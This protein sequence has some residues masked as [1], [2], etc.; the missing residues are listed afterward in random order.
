MLEFIPNFGAC[1]SLNSIYQELEEANDSIAD[2]IRDTNVMA[3][4]VSNGI[5]RVKTWGCN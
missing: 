5:Y 4:G 2:P 1:Y 3:T